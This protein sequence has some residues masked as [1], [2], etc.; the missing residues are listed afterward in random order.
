MTLVYIISYTKVDKLEVS[1]HEVF[2]KI[3]ERLCSYLDLDMSFFYYYCVQTLL[4]GSSR[5]Y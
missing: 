1:D 4:P 3:S 5:E 2:D